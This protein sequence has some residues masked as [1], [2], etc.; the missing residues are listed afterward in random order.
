MFVETSAACAPG[1]SDAN[2]HRT[3]TI[4]GAAM[5]EM[6]RRLAEEIVVSSDSLLLRAGTGRATVVAFLL[7]AALVRRGARRA[8]PEAG[9][10]FRSALAR[11]SIGD[12]LQRGPHRRIGMRGAV[13]VVDC[14]VAGIL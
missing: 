2:R 13:A 3:A 14:F 8:H 7:G 10:R 9:A 5:D 11:L 6:R 12:S 1:E 4:T